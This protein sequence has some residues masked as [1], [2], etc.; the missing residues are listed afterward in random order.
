M[1]IWGACERASASVRVG[2]DE[3][4]LPS[5]RRCAP[6]APPFQRT[7]RTAEDGEERAE[8][9]LR[10]LNAF[11]PLVGRAP[12]QPLNPQPHTLRIHTSG[13]GTPPRPPPDGPHYNSTPDHLPASRWSTA[14][15]KTRAGEVPTKSR[16]LAR[17]AHVCNP[18]CKPRAS[19]VGEVSQRPRRVG[20]GVSLRDE[21]LVSRL[22]GLERTT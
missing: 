14:L 15:P 11:A 8:E 5:L 10:A 2:G 4:H 13:R 18:R 20:R 6:G 22:D 16:T 21:G 17:I 7:H 1:V 19:R 9:V 3:G 12:S